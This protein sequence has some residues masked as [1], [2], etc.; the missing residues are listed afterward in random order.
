M[1]D[2]QCCVSFWCTSKGFGYLYTYKYILFNILFHYGL[3]QGIGYSSLCF[4]VDF[5]VYL[6]Y[7]Q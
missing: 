4:M 3:L 5:V 1:I 7:I 2:L 6:F